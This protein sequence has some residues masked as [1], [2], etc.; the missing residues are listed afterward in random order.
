MSFKIQEYVLL[1]FFSKN[2][3]T[4][5]KWFLFFI[6]RIIISSCPGKEILEMSSSE[7]VWKIHSYFHH[8]YTQNNNN[9]KTTAILMIVST[10]EYALALDF[11]L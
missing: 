5:K 11:E 1:Q 10:T 4:R 9:I 3:I 2:F 6:I 7:Y 8:H